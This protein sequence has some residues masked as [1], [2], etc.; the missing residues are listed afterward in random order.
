[1][2]PVA[3]RERAAVA[4]AAGVPTG[5][6]WALGLTW[7]AGQLDRDLQSALRRAGGGQRLWQA[8]DELVRR[9][10][11]RVPDIGRQFLSA[12]RD[13]CMRDIRA[14]IDAKGAWFVEP[15]SGGPEERLRT[16]HDPPLGLIGIGERLAAS[17]PEGAPRVAIVGS[18]RPTAFGL[19]FTSDLAACLGAVG[20]VII[21][22][23]AIGVDAAAHRGAL[24]VGA[25]TV[26]VLGC[27]VGVDHPRTNSALRR[28]IVASG[29]TVVSEYW[30]TTRP[31]RWRFPARNR[32]VAGMA[33]VVI[34]TEAAAR[35]GALI[36][37]D[38]ALELG[39]PVLAVPGRPGAPASAGC[40]ALLR[41]GAAF[42]ETVDDVVAEIPDALWDVGV[43]AGQTD[44]PDGLAG[45]IHTLL[46]SQPLS[47]AQIT[48][49]LG[50]SATEVATSLTEM[51]LHGSV[52]TLDGHLYTVRRV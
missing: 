28:Q 20:A 30:L 19:Q 50:D 40:H 33:D 18:R 26:A 6:D 42:C 45:R 7:I 37:A 32:I 43:R 24:A 35:S 9:V 13:I 49:E 17:C 22:G 41:A 29:G 39:R 2:H 31:N 47:L 27:G 5:E 21:S 44:V 11:Q 4:A 12:R 8:P 14:E 34:V 15:G 38:F 16:L 51:E 1:M 46:S 25:H 48:E 10:F 3:E 36:T 52:V 23:L